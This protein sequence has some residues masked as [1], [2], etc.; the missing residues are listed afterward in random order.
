M[1]T[2]YISPLISLTTEICTTYTLCN[3]NFS[4]EVSNN[5]KRVLTKPSEGKLNDGFDNED[6]NLILFV[7]DVLGVQDNKKY[8]V[9]DVLGHGT[10]AQ[11]VKCQDLTT[12]EFVAVKIVKSNYAC[13]HQSLSEV[14]LLEFINQKVDPE[15]KYHLLRLKDKFLFKNHLCLVFEL[16]SSNLFEL[17]KQNEYKGLNTSLVRKLSKQLLESFVVLKRAGIIHCDLKPEN[18]LLISPDKPDI[19]VVDFGS[20]CKEHQTLFTYVQSR[21]YRSPEVILGLPYSSSIDAWSLG[22]VI[23]ELFLGLPLFAGSSEYDQ[24]LKIVSILGIPPS[25]MIDM[26]KNGKNFFMK[27]E[28]TKEYQMKPLAQYCTER[29]LNEKPGEKFFDTND[30]NKLIM[31]YSMNKKAMTSTMIEKENNDR[32]SLLNLLRG[33]L[34]WSPLERW[35]PQQAIQ[36][37]FITGDRFTGSWNP[38][39]SEASAPK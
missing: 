2:A 15:D 38:P 36:H 17:V 26:G 1:T 30:F 7:N 23:A 29:K 31:N 28:I 16:L 21:F 14:V 24:I 13:T 19:K 34:M 12:K 20:A 9:L 11:V 27:D 6:A 8:L 32:E 35:T 37:P 10:F 5:P 25:W 39:G 3:S 22:C 4:Y 18:I 33:L